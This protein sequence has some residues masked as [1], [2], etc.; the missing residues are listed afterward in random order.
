MENMQLTGGHKSEENPS[1]ANIGQREYF[2]SKNK[3]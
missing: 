3:E 2:K 1:E